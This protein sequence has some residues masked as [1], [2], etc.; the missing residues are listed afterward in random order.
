MSGISEKK[1]AGVEGRSISNIEGIIV[2]TAINVFKID[3]GIG[4]LR[5]CRYRCGIIA[6][7]SRA[8]EADIRRYRLSARLIETDDIEGTRAGIYR[9]TPGF[10]NNEVIAITTSNDVSAVAAINRVIAVIAQD[11][12]I[13]TQPQIAVITREQVNRVITS[14]A[15]KYIVSNGGGPRFFLKSKGCEALVRGAEQGPVAHHPRKID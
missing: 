1:D 3:D 4:A 2:A 13:S 15:R 11:R 14:S 9:I 8:N 12:I 7:S 6:P 10:A 5:G